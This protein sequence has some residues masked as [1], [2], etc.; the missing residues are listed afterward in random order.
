[1]IEV[2]PAILPKNYED[3]KNKI[4]L[5]RGV[6]P[7]VQIDL[8]D[9]VMVPSSTWPFPSNTKGGSA[10]NSDK[11][12]DHFV[13]ILNEQ[14]GLPFWEDVDFEI[15]LMVGDAVKNF[16]LYSKLGSRRIVFHLGEN[17]DILE[18]REFLE[19]LDNYVRDVFEVGVALNVDRNPETIFPLVPE[20]DFVQCMGIEKPGFQGEEFDPRVV[21][22]IKVL[23][24][25]YD[26]L[27]ISVD[28]G[29]TPEISQLLL[30]AGATRLI[31]GSYIFKSNDI[32]Q[33][34]ERLRLI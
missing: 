1:M 16:D 10:S 9:G 32:G 14:E 19:G 31:S 15:D 22:N 20:L 13:S 28:G 7:V 21:D 8:C 25:K 12:D 2:I 29:V 5:I 24:A 34:I 17:D 18:L 6:A 4:S 30:E 3:L 11:L 26:D 33:A 23:R 27:P